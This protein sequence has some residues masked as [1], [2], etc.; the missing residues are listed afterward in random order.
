[1]TTLDQI[2]AILPA[3]QPSQ[4]ARDIL[5]ATPFVAIVGPSGSGKNTILN[6]LLETGHFYEIVTDTTRQPRSNNGVPEQNGVDYFFQTQEQMLK[7]LQDGLMVEAAVYATNVYGASIRE[8]EKAQ[9]LHKAAI[10]DIEVTGVNTIVRYKP[11]LIAVFLLPPS[12]EEWLARLK[13]R[14]S[15]MTDQELRSRLVTACQEIE[16]ALGQDYYCFV[17]ND[18]LQ[19]AIRESDAIAQ[20]G[21]QEQSQQLKA[22][23]LARRLLVDTREFLEIK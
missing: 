12:F 18:A 4:T 11:D 23:D 10:V 14:G 9:K 21:R 7:N 3:Y 6:A 19:V 22:R 2:K 13:K 8:I 17:V 5:R 20:A 16:M 1:M 15:A